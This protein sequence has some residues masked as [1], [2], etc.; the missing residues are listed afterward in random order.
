MQ[1]AIE[2]DRMIETE[3]EGESLRERGSVRETKTEVNNKEKRS[4]RW[5]L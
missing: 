1:R 4:Q 3:S 2:I 5:N